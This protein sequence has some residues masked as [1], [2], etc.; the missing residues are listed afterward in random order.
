MSPRAVQSAVIGNSRETFVLHFCSS[1]KSANRLIL[2]RDLKLLDD[3]GFTALSSKLDEVGRMLSGLEK[4][5]RGE[6][7][8]GSDIPQ[9]L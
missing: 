8:D 6:D 7:D 5:L 9:F 1:T 4:R 3:A 2:M